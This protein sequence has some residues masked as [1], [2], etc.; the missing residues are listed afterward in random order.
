MP[1]RH[2]NGAGTIVVQASTIAVRAG[3][4]SSTCAGTFS[5]S[6]IGHLGLLA[7]LAAARQKQPHKGA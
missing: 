5:V 2:N 7:S 1:I 4:A 6:Y 3:F